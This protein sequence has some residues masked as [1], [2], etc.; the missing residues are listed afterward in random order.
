MLW[1]NPHIKPLSNEPTWCVRFPLKSATCFTSTSFTSTVLNN[2][3]ADSGYVQL[4]I[5]LVFMIVWLGPYLYLDFPGGSVDKCVC[6]Q[7]G[8]PRFDPWVRKMPWRRKWQLI[9]VLLP[10]ESHGWKSLVGCNPWCH[11]ES[12]R[13]EPLHLHLPLST[14]SPI[15]V[16]CFLKLFQFDHSARFV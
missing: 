16:M 1:Q 14:I 4:N 2:Y 15:H 13:A 9:P 12:D 8:R 11:I 3:L 6:L 10:G 5:L 7:C